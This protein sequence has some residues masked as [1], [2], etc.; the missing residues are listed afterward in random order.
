MALWDLRTLIEHY[1]DCLNYAWCPNPLQAIKN[2]VGSHCDVWRTNHNNEDFVSHWCSHAFSESQWGIWV[3][4]APHRWSTGQVLIVALFFTSVRHRLNHSAPRLH[5]E[6][7]M[8]FSYTWQPLT[9]QNQPSEPNN[10]LI[11]FP[12]FGWFDRFCGQF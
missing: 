12:N 2:R 10:N 7:S 1:S 3:Q 9:M 6:A 8:V 4:G 11:F 5:L